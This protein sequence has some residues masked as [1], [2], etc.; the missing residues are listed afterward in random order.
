M[1]ILLIVLKKANIKNRLRRG[2]QFIIR[3]NEDISE[4]EH[5]NS[6]SDTLN[7]FRIFT[8]TLL[9]RRENIPFVHVNK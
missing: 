4:L 7:V 9:Y 8:Q 3:R 6:T 5:K 2:G 1:L